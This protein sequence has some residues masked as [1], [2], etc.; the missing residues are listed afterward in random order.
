MTG[1]MDDL[2]DK[3]RNATPQAIPEEL[4]TVDGMMD[5]AYHHARRV[6]VGEPKET[7]MMPAWCILT[8][9]G[10]TAIIATPFFDDPTKDAV[11]AAMRVLMAEVG[12]IRYTMVSEAWLAT[13]KTPD[14]R[15][16]SERDDRVEVIMI[17]GC[18]KGNDAQMRT[19]EMIR[20]WETGSVTE[21]RLMEGDSEIVGGRFI[22]LLGD[23]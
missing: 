10:Q 8:E 17:W 6:L 19:Y 13:G 4:S 1:Q 23:D 14:R 3:I 16:P 9:S 7:T 21:L 18:G 15:A 5:I 20:D 11:A 12:A 2:I 22:G